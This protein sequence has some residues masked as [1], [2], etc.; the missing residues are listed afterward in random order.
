MCPF[1]TQFV[2]NSVPRPCPKLEA[3]QKE[4]KRS[5]H[6][7]HDK[8]EVF[9]AHMAQVQSPFEEGCCLMYVYTTAFHFSSNQ[10]LHD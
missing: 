1:E 8:S 3:K 5:L 4:Q 10:V 7:F 2:S 6:P 9:H